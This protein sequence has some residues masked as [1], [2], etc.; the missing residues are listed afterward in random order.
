MASG[1]QLYLH[2]VSNRE[3]F[4]MLAR[5]RGGFVVLMLIKA[6]LLEAS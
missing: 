5:M 4:G 2:H 6:G 3:W 1:W